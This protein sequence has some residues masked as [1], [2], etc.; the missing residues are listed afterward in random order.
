[1]MTYK[2]QGKT[3]SETLGWEGDY[4]KSEEQAFDICRKLSNNRKDKMQP[5]TLAEYRLQNEIA[6]ETVKKEEQEEKLRNIRLWR[7]IL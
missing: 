3:V 4:I 7:N 5:F 6:L 2:W 1:M